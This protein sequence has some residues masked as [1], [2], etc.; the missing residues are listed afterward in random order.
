MTKTT[1]DDDPWLRSIAEIKEVMSYLEKESP[2]GAVTRHRVT[3]LLK[4][5]LVIMEDCTS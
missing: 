3:K 2:I 1:P 5:Y 4:E